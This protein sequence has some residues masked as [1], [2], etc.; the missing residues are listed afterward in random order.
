MSR[1]SKTRTVAPAALLASASSQPSDSTGQYRYVTTVA[2][3]T[4]VPSVS[5]PSAT[6]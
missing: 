5:V 1:T 6:P 3:A 2:A 4:S